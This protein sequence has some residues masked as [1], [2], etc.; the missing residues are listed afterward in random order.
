MQCHCA[1]SWGVWSLL[2][3]CLQDASS[4]CIPCLGESPWFDS[5]DLAPPP[6]VSHAGQERKFTFDV[7]LEL[8]SL[9]GQV[10]REC[11]LKRLIDMA[12]EGYSSTVFAFGQTGS[13]KTY[14][15]TGPHSLVSGRGRPQELSDIGLM[16]RSLSY[17][18]DQVQHREGVA[19]SASYLE[20][21]NEQVRDLLNPCRPET[22]AVRGSK[23]RGFHVEN[24]SSVEI[25]SLGAAME[26]LQGG[27]QNRQTSSHS[28]NDHSSR[29]HSIF[30]VYI[31]S[32]MA[33]AEGCAGRLSR[34]GKLCVV[35]LAGSERAKDTGELMEETG[36]INRS[37][38]TLGKCISALV[39]PKK[40]GGHIPY[41]DSKLTKLLYDSLG[42]SGVTLMIA[43]V[44]PTVAN[45]QET[46]NTLRYASRAKKIKN[47]P[48]AKRVSI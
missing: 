11:G 39:D 37:L 29:S 30:T 40:R 45:L 26:I 18:L 15:T 12:I 38:L 47:R 24:L 4:K 44:S 9:Q 17:L 5:S 33:E 41:R 14:T 42:G 28:Q 34:H 31:E 22:L 32:E 43:C 36:S 13:G 21:Y 3:G 46:M 7:A 19:L 1:G 20:I 10:F 25:H 35:D 16:Q 2:S 48:M 23:T 27:M 6:Q 8:D